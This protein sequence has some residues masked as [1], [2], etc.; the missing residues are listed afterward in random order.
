MDV[1]GRFSLNA[2]LALAGNL[3]APVAPGK[4]LGSGFVGN[5]IS[6]TKW[7]PAVPAANR[8]FSHMRPDSRS[9][10]KRCESPHYC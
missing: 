2:P 8:L 10:P 6:I 7:P 3:S 9:R 5:F 4:N 1:P